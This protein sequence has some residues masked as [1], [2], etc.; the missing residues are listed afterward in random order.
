M[1]ADAVFEDIPGGSRVVAREL[2][3]G[4]GRR[5]HEITFL[6]ARQTPDAPNSECLDGVRIIRYRGAGRAAEFV[7][8]GRAVCA[9]L[10]AEGPFDIVHSHFAYSALGPLSVVPKRTPHVRSFYGPWHEEG[11]VEDLARANGRARRLKA[12]LKRWLRHQVEAV[13]LRRSQAVVVLSEQSR[14]E[15]LA[16]GFPGE[17]VQTIAGG[18]DVERFRTAP[19]RVRVRKE[20]GLPTDRKLLLSVRRLA[21]RMGLDNLIQVMPSIVARCPDML[22]LIGG[23][24]PERERLEQLTR[25]L[26]MEQ[27]VQLVG[28][29]PD[30]RLAAYYQS[31]DLF[32]LPTVALEG[33][34]LVTVEALSCGVPVV[35][36][37][38]GA[39]PEILNRL[40]PRLVA[41]GTS[42]QSLG[43]SILAF[44]DQDWKRD[45]TPERLHGFVRENYTWETH[46]QA[47][48]SLYYALLEDLKE[49]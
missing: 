1:L 27:H 20:L 2:A 37:P 42:P 28:F 26:D 48:E 21:P 19:D 24:G 23:K 31:A 10:W 7:R 11:W 46:V 44:L 18:V 15:V 45:L 49:G 3:Q 14:R 40:D 16:F 39:T 41:G 43:Q 17:R 36:T 4:L 47:V 34:G 9:R 8:A 5:G 38:V 32:V 33:F 30:E 13:N 35:G 25:T 12:R 22:L 6:V 29:I